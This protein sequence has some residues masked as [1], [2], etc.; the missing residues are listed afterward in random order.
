AKLEGIS[1]SEYL[2]G[3]AYLN[4]IKYLEHSPYLLKA[5][6]QGSSRAPYHV[7]LIR[8]DQNEVIFGRCSCPAYESYDEC[9]HI[10]AVVLDGKGNILKNLNNFYFESMEY[11]DDYLFDGADDDHHFFMPRAPLKK[12]FG[13]LYKNFQWALEEAKAS[14]KEDL[15]NFYQEN[16]ASSNS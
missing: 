12:T 8:D 6:V 5:Q 15:D 13:Q 7:Q 1:N 9:K 2:K 10:A 14:S 11:A 3:R 4:K 16:Q